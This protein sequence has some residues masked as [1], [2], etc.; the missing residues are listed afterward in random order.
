[1]RNPRTTWVGALHQV[2]N[3]GISSEHI[4]ETSNL[5]DALLKSVLEK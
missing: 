3:R 5:K 4:P 1:M 2:R